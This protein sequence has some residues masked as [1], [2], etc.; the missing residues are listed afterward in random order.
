MKILSWAS[1]SVLFEPFLVGVS[2]SS[3][4]FQHICPG[5]ADIR[6]RILAEKETSI[7]VPGLLPIFRVT[8]GSHGSSNN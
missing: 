5:E 7:L 1:H 3:A 6:W 8:L 4:A 2:L